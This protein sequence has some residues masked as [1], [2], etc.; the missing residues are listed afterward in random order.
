MNDVN[1]TSNGC[2]LS[3]ELFYKVWHAYSSG[4]IFLVLLIVYL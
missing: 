1:K 2:C 4:K 3:D